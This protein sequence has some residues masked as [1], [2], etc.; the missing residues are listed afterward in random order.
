MKHVYGIMGM[1][2]KLERSTRPK[3]AVGLDTPDGVARWDAA[4]EALANALDAFAGGT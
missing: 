2:Y 1:T 4:E 3:K